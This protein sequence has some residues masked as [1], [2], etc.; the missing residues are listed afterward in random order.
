MFG[1]AAWRPACASYVCYHICMT[2]LEVG[3]DELQKPSVEAFFVADHAD[4]VGGKV[5]VNGGFW[6]RLQFPSYPAVTSYCDR[7]SSARPGPDVP[8]R[9]RLYGES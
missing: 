1:F 8:G 9:T 6:S 2:D 4:V 3:V 7:R 5:Y